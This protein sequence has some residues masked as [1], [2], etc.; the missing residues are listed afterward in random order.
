[1]KRVA[2]KLLCALG[3]PRRHRERN[4]RRLLVLMYHGVSRSVLS[5]FCWHQLPVDAFRRQ[6]TWVREHY[7][8]LPLSE[9][10]AS[11]GDG[12]LPDLAASITFDDGFRNNLTRALP[13]LE[14]LGLPATIFLP[15]GVVGTSDALWPDRLYLTVA[16]AKARALDAAAI[17]LGPLPL[18]SK[19]DKEAAI[20]R[21]LRELKQRPTAEVAAFLDD[22][23]AAL[24]APADTGEFALVSWEQAAELSASP[25][26][27][28]AAHTET[29]PIL[30]QCDDA[31]VEQEIRGSHAALERR[32][33]VRPT[34]FAYPNGRL[35]DF[36]ERARRAVASCDV[37]WAVST[38]NGLASEASDPLALP[39]M[40]IGSDLSFDRFRLL[41]SG[42][43]APLRS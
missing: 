31:R 20:Q 17:G 32:L 15:T 23:E 8:V 26:I 12:A 36:D 19:G 22:T 24:G 39:R 38:E 42:A 30:A 37:R 34:V 1:M 13:V 9:A 7:N 29:H 16:N 43:L 18:G 28:L 35:V 2:E 27:E 5:P 6:L 33:G 11:L 41:V 21:C 40:C 10:I 3:W 14:E 25:L 4:R